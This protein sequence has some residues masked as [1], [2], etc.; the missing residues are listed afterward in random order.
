MSAA[1]LDQFTGLFLFGIDWRLAFGSFPS[2]HYA[3]LI[4]HLGQAWTLGAELAFYAMVPFLLRFWKVTVMLLVASLDFRGVMVA[5]VGHDPIL[6]YIFFRSTLCFF[7]LGQFVC[8]AGRRWPIVANPA[9]LG[10]DPV[11]RRRVAGSLRGD[12]EHTLDE[13][14]R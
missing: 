7:L 4:A 12:E 8:L 3:A 6:T 13:S 9:L 14:S 11:F 5:N 10:L 1:V 2:L